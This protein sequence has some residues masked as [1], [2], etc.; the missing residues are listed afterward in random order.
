VRGDFGSEVSSALAEEGGVVADLF[1]GSFGH[2]LLCEDGGFRL[3]IGVV[4]LGCGGLLMI[5]RG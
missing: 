1:R 4:V 5:E 3:W 2:F